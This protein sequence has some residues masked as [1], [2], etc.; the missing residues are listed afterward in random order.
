[1]A[2]EWQEKA[3]AINK[4]EDYQDEAGKRLALYREKKPYHEVLRP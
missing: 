1:M 4:A 2:A 3:M